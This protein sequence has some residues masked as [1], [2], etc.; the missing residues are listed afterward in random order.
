[1]SAIFGLVHLDNKPVDAG[2]LARMGAALQAHGTEGGSQWQH[3]PV[4][5][6]QR[7]T[8][9]TPQDRYEQQ[10][11]PSADGWCRLI[12]NGRLDNR[13]E[14]LALFQMDGPADMVT[15]SALILKAYERWGEACVHHLIGVFTFALW[16]ERTQTLLVVRSA[17]SSPSLYFYAD[18]KT[19]AFASMPKGLFALADIPRKINEQYLAEYLARIGGEPDACL[20]HGLTRLVPGQM[21]RIQRDRWSLHTFWGDAPPKDE[22]RFARDE[23]YVAAFLAL[24]QRVIQDHLRC[25]SPV[26]V[27]MS[28]GL[29]ST[30]VAAVAASLYGE[31]GWTLP[32]FTEVPRT[33]FDGAIIAG[34]YADE[35]PYVEAMA[36]RYETLEANLIRTDGQVYIENLD[37]YFAAA[38]TPFPNS[39]N[40]VWY[41]GILQAAQSQGLLVL[42][43]GESGNQTI[44]WNGNGLLA[45]LI[46]AGEW[47]RLGREVQA[48]ARGKGISTAIKTLLTQGIVP[49]LPAAIY[50]V[51]DRV[52]SLNASGLGSL[53]DWRQHSPI[54]PEF[55]A[56]HNIDEL[57]LAR[58]RHLLGRPSGDTRTVRLRALVSRSRRADGISEGY[59]ARYG[60]TTSDPTGDVRLIDFCLALPESQYQRNGV[61]RWLIR[62][63]MAERLPPE[64]LHNPQ[65]GLQ[66]ADWYDR[67]VGARSALLDE[68]TRIEQCDLAQQALDLP[69]LRGL[70]MQLGND[71]SNRVGRQFAQYRGV[72]ERGLMTG[73]FIR[74][75]EENR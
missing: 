28:G 21:L 16:D 11:T 55:A 20:Y 69:R 17:C 73:S 31:K 27:M 34:R 8:I 68:L 57:F 75:V 18:K 35:T 46:G 53:A 23:E 7:Q 48:L 54:R 4:G 13:P 2:D 64:V 29:D 39:S 36:R 14:L 63:A 40:R 10:P 26:G 42:L 30:S 45:Q 71:N 70:V 9:M 56:A 5:L 33:H 59:Q 25:L 51:L 37:A 50:L 65:R 72:L 67:L 44:S 66:A 38:E 12:V 15:D 1:M 41:E 19:V 47:A 52:R 60:V 62:R 49:H 22:I 3:G 58:E 32:T 74:W 6:G 61:S 43:T 24:F